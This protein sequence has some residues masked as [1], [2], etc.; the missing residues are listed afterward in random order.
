MLNHA[1]WA[2]ILGQNWTELDR[3]VIQNVIHPLLKCDT[4]PIIVT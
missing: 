2:E 4:L 3:N 1:V